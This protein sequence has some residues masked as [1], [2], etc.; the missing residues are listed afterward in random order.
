MAV[1][2]LAALT[3]PLAEDSTCGAD[4]EWAGVSALEE[5]AT[6]KPDKQIGTQIVPAEEP[7]WNAVRA[8][9]L[10]LFESTRDLRVAVRLAM[11]LLHTASWAGLADGLQMVQILLTNYWD[12]VHP[13]LDPADQL[14]PTLRLS[15]IGALA[16]AP[17]VL[18]AIRLL[19]LASSRRL[20][21]VTFRDVLLAKGDLKAREDETAMDKGMVDSIFRDADP[22]PLAETQRQVVAAYACA[23]GIDRQ[24]EEKDAGHVL[25][26]LIA[27]LRDIKR[28]LADRVAP[29]AGE[30]DQ[31]GSVE[32]ESGAP[33]RAATF[34]P[35]E[36]ATRAE[37][38]TAIDSVIAYFIRHEP[39]SPIPL[40]L[41][42]ARALV[43]KDFLAIVNDLVPAGREQLDVLRGGVSEEAAVEE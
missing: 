23:Q 40:L 22:A 26:P 24:F 17:T 43:G 28:A 41:A 39:S 42:R 5:L 30:A 12:A 2:D 34:R 19:P 4:L 20:G 6:V 18:R 37:A 21:Q 3:A 38:I 13:R 25:E 9:A 15:V 7:D 31:D 29:E 16:E 27:L 1:I 35:G 14:D 32:G 10:T 36:L 8:Q 33:S 11:A